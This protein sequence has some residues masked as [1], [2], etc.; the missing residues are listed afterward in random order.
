MTAALANNAMAHSSPFLGEGG[1]AAEDLAVAWAVVRYA[2]SMPAAVEDRAA[3]ETAQTELL[4]LAEALGLDDEALKELLRSRV[5]R[6]GPPLPF[7][8]RF[9]DAPA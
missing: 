6:E 1:S 2:H 9:D 3:L 7:A 4:Q 8:A 5:E